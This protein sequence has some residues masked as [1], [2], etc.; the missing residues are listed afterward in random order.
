MKYKI[1]SEKNLVF[2]KINENFKQRSFRCVLIRA[3]TVRG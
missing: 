3:G 2:L 1:Y